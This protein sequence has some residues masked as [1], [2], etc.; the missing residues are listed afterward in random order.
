M[1]D[2]GRGD[3]AQYDTANEMARWREQFDF[4]FV[5][6][7]GDNIYAAGTPENYAARFE[8]PYKALIDAGV[9]VLRGARQPRS[10]RAVELPALSHERQSVLLVHEER[11]GAADR[12]RRRSQFFA[13]DTV[14]PRQ[15]SAGVAAARARAARRADW[16]IC[17]YHHPLYTS[18]RYRTAAFRLRTQAR[19]DL[20][21]V[22]RGRRAER[23]RALLRAHRA[24]WRRAVLHVRRG[25]R[26][27]AGT[28]SARRRSPRPASTPTLT[29]C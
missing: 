20:P 13:L 10:A 5:L 19:A 9:D 7:L 14:D 25:R 28:T 16:K 27:A 6:M 21:A 29:S 24:A 11:G 3:R 15:R 4:S 8:R 17:F 1:G 18:G 2:T 26:A 22:R 12:H 23:P